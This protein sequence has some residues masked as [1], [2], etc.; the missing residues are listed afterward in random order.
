MDAKRSDCEFCRIINR[1]IPAEVVYETESELAFFPLEPATRGHTM[2]IPKHHVTSFLDPTALTMTGLWPTTLRVAKAIE[3]VLQP[4]GMN[5]I[6]SSGEVASQTVMHMHMHI[7]PRWLGDRMGS[8][9]PP[10]VSTPERMLD[11]VADDI[12][13]YCRTDYLADRYKQ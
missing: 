9:W 4:E 5:L 8:I 1:E 7:V 12:R 3:K 13:E 2:I 11:K 6:T 10:K